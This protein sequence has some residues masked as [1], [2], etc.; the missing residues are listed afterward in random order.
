MQMRSVSSR[1]PKTFI[2]PVW[3]GCLLV[4]VAVLGFG[5]VASAGAATVGH[6]DTSFG[7]RGWIST[8][9]S[10][11]SEGLE[12]VISPD[13]AVTLVDPVAGLLIGL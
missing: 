5:T 8:P 11:R 9:P 12:P 4:A 6:L 2:G 10:I 7:H 13:G 3:L 1:H